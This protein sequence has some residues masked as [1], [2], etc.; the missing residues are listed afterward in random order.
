MPVENFLDIRSADLAEKLVINFEHLAN[1][2]H[3]TELKFPVS[4]MYVPLF[5]SLTLFKKRKLKATNEWRLALFCMAT[6]TFECEYEVSEF[7]CVVVIED[8][9]PEANTDSTMEID[10]IPDTQ[11]NTKQKQKSSTLLIGHSQTHS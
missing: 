9:D 2:G 6:F 10:N 1:F 5:K 11:K 8:P 4:S 7:S 3:I